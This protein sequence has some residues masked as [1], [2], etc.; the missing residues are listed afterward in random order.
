MTAEEFT[1]RV[2]VRAGV[3]LSV[4]ERVFDE[5]GLVPEL[6][7]A[8][9]RP[10]RL[11]RLR[12]V[13][14]RSVD[15][16]GPFDSDIHF[17]PGLTVLAAD[18]LRG[19][20]SVFEL[21][22]WCL[23]GSPRSGLQG[24]VRSWL[25]RVD[26]DAVVAGRFLG[27]RLLI[28]G[29]ELLEGRV[30][31]AAD[32]DSLIGAENARPDRGVVEILH[33]TDQ[34]TFSAMVEALM[35]ELLHLERLESI[36]SQASS[37]KAIYGWPAY[38]GALYLPPGGDQA[39]LGDVVVG[40]L[41]GR[42]LQV[43]LDLPSAALLTRI[44][45]ARDHL[46]DMERVAEADS[47]R[48]R[49][50]LEGQRQAALE[51]LDAVQAELATLDEQPSTATL[52]EALSGLTAS[53]V[54]AEVSLRDARQTYEV[55]RW[56][57]RTDEK[58][59]NDIREHQAARLLFHALDPQVCPRCEAPISPERRA[60][61]RT[62]AICAVCTE[63]TGRSAPDPQQAAEAEQEAQWRLTA[64]RNAEAAAQS[65]RDATAAYADE[66]RKA[67]ADAERA[68]AMAQAGGTADRR[69]ELADRIARLEGA[70]AALE[71]LPKPVDHR[72]GDVGAVLNAAV[73]ILTEDQSMASDHLLGELNANIVELARSFGFRNLD[74]V[75]VDRAGRL[76]VYKTG[77]PREW[78][79][80][81]SSGE[82]LRLRIA[83]VVA[84]LRIGHRR[85]IATHPGLLLIDSPRSEEV[86]DDD[87]AALLSALERLCTE[88]PGL[89]I[90]V[91]TADEAL[92]RRT[93]TRST[94]IAPSGPGLP[95]W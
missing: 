32:G 40:G 31:S 85:G 35:M 55:L 38:F 33:A 88:T 2:A 4:A 34:E 63:P 9:P 78:F 71:S 54:A 81:Q 58:R 19:K 30:L 42:L 41:A 43:F 48:L 36:S 6:S 95:L 44:K 72:R 69:R 29:G 12:I 13:G 14:T 65:H 91:T 8:L 80:T 20:T 76:Q 82:R 87:A 15:P 26:C 37:G 28:E 77:G 73:S 59:L 50:L 74:R 90:L 79:K 11:C 7:G 46:V 5:H 47:A 53:A 68:L 18:N 70:V 22:T 86:Q 62:R 83:V 57:R 3:P 56:Q 64:S 17:G 1:T 89:Q 60:A 94:I 84:L 52:V 45:A 67:L 49:R 21:A 39:L 27:F 16:Q 51:Q 75:A 24:V 10:V 25:S 93:L 61:E 92:V 66:Q 23:R